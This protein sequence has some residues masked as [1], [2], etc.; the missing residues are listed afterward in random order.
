LNSLRPA[1]ESKSK[2]DF[3]LYAK[4]VNLFFVLANALSFGAQSPEFTP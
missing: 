3:I 4:A 2:L 1:N